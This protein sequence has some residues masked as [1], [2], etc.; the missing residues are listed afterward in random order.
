MPA[1]FALSVIAPLTLA[2]LLALRRW[3]SGW[4]LAS[5][6]A[7]LLFGMVFLTFN[8]PWFLFSYWVLAGL[9]AVVV[10]SILSGLFKLAYA[11]WRRPSIPELV[12]T[13]ALLAGVV[14]F[15]NFAVAVFAATR[16]P[17]EAVELAFPLRGGVYAI[18]QGGSAPPLQ[19]GHAATPSQIFGLDAVRLN[20]FGT[21]SGKYLS[22]DTSVDHTLGE[23]VFSP[24]DGEVVW[25]RD[26]IP[27]IP[28]LGG[29][30][31]AGNAVA[32]SCK[33]IVV[34]LGHFENGSVTV[35][36][37]DRV[38]TGTQLGRIGM[39]GNT[40]GPHLHF[41]AERG[42]WQGDFSSNPGVAMTFDGRFLWD[43]LLV[44]RRD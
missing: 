14:Y 29:D 13:S 3:R 35:E 28:R 22:A 5:L 34:G 27:D 20:A 17:D 38:Q 36:V 33:G 8:A 4:V 16:P 41:H 30:T 11:E 6:I 18:I 9:S 37:G 31:P 19:R 23:P 39:S 1:F 43:L 40:A 12:L 25:S 24:C 32:V 26:G 44:D 21:T 10:A 2:M 42:A 7:F 15:A